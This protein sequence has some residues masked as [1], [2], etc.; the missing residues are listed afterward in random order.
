MQHNWKPPFYLYVAGRG[1]GK[2][3][4][5]YNDM[6]IPSP[7][8]RLLI[9]YTLS[10]QG[11]LY[12]K[13]QRFELNPGDVFVIERPGPYVYCYESDGEPWNFAYVSIGFTS[14]AGLLPPALRENPVLSLTAHPQLKTML[15]ELVEIRLDPEFR[16]S[17]L[18]SALA[19]R[20]LL[21]FIEAKTE[22]RTPI[23]PAAEKLRA[24][25]VKDFTEPV[26]LGDLCRKLLYSQEALTRI[27]TATY[28]LP[29]V[30]FLRELRLRHALE[31][32]RNSS[33]SVKE[34][35]AASGFSSENYFCRVFRQTFGTTPASYA[36]NPNPLLSES[37]EL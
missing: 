13:D 30:K 16:A 4:R 32:L 2:D 35:A 37:L 24:R 15:E 6:K 29:P 3:R 17:L 21:T 11:T 8:R 34:I 25:L 18:D 12:V 9:K 14:P 10:G 22:A 23:H 20:F 1:S 31:L 26:K 19:Y 5:Y 33:L 27:F 7:P 36:R 28:G